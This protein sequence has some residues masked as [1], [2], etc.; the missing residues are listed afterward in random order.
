MQIEE[1]FYS[2]FWI[3]ALSII[4]FYTDWVQYYLQLLGIFKTTQ[5]KYKSFIVDNPNKYFPDFLYSIS[6][7]VDNRLGKFLLKL[8][9][10]PFCLV[11]WLSSFSGILCNNLLNV[12]PVYVLSM[13]ILLQ[14]RKM[15]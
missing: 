2:V 3:S 14:I 12:G 11:F 1:I 7:N 8:I 9:S 10:C 4:W 15:I 13:F 5:L 6:L